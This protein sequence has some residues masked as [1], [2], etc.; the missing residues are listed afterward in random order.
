MR[1]PQERF[2]DK[3]DVIEVILLNN[4][5]VPLYKEAQDKWPKLEPLDLKLK[6][7]RE[8]GAGSLALE[9][10]RLFGRGNAYYGKPMM[11]EL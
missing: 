9:F 7:L 6:I 2:E 11:E 5:D 1:I 4:F 3:P 10:D 8:S